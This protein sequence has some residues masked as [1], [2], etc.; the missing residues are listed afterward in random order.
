MKPAFTL[1]LAT[2]L[3][4][5][6]QTGAQT[7][8][9]PDQNF[10]NALVNTTCADLDGDGAFETDADIN[11][12][13]S[14]QINE[15]QS[16]LGLGVYSRQISS[17]EGIQ[18]FTNLKLLDCSGNFLTELPVTNLTTLTYLECSLN[19]LTAL[20]VHNLIHLKSLL[21][22]LN[23]LE[24][25]DVQNLTD[26][27]FLSCAD[28]SLSVLE[29]QNLQKL[30]ELHCFSNQLT[31][32]D[33]QG[34][35][36]LTV[37]ECPF[38]QLPSLNL[39][40][41]T[42]LTA[43]NCGRNELDTLDLHGLPNLQLLGCALNNLTSLDVQLLPGLKQL[44]CGSNELTELNL[45]GLAQLERVE[46]AGNELTTLDL[47]SSPHLNYLSCEYNQLAT[48]YIKNGEDAPWF[49]P[50][51]AGNPLLYICCNEPQIEFMEIL[52]ENAE[53]TNC[54]VNSYC[55]FVSAGPVHVLTGSATADVESDGCDSL[56]NYYPHLVF[57]IGNEAGSGIFTTTTSGTYFVPLDSGTYR[58][59]PEN[60]LYFAVS[61]DTLVLEL[62]TPPDTILQN[63]CVTPAGIYHDVETGI[64]PLTPARPGFE[65]TY[66]IYCNNKGT[67]P[68]SGHVTFVF[69]DILMNFMEATPQ[70]ARQTT[71]T[72]RWGFTDLPPLGQITFKVKFL[73]N[74]PTQQPP[75]HI[76]DELLFS[77]RAQIPETDEFLRDNVF[78][79]LQ[80]TVG[81]YDPNDKTC[82]EGNRI[83]P[84]MTGDYLHY[85][86]RFENTGTFAAE[87]VVV[88]D[89]IDTTSFDPASL[90]LIESSHDCYVRINGN[91]VEFIFENIQLPFTEPGKHGFVLFKVKTRPALPLGTVLTNKANI[92]FDFNQ[93]VVTNV[94]TTTVSETIATYSPTKHPMNLRLQPNPAHD[95]LFLQTD[96][97]V[98]RVEI[99]DAL[100]RIVL[101]SGVQ[102]G[103]ID[104]A[105]LPQGVYRVKV[106]S[107]NL[108]AMKQVVKQ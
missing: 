74:M 27:E 62:S 33:V 46:C 95:M 29:V 98:E 24:T 105:R 39:Q 38:N 92:Y 101:S 86:I 8:N 76:G 3:L 103:Q 64:L 77:A 87:N 12:D 25:L 78:E 59:V 56:D 20:D 107:G 13:G 44:Y 85:L 81:S 67:Q 6:F 14:I 7:L 26:L 102:N 9:I 58:I 50:G 51:F 32:L 97:P 93:P 40:G 91:L 106:F 89:S 48:L 84:E 70:P 100:G 57:Q 108:F 83:S 28:C 30:K 55:D 52:L 4:F 31:A 19:H 1:L 79:L 60:P 23:P 71:D 45:Y 10:L 68:Q 11:N 99:F 49:T 47:R 54:V 18:Q 17:L 66:L 15:A 16:V 43:L 65:S 88:R 21:C 96:Q 22:S 53:I 41:L 69:S 104:I 61:P 90:R 63:F 42:R 35:D 5:S 2:L 75:V 80:T 37:L 94:A 34:L 73:L 82:L 72:L 36:S